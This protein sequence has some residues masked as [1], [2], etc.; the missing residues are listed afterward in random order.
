MKYLLLII[1]CFVSLEIKSQEISQEWVRSFSISSSG[2]QVANDAITDTEG[3][4]YVTGY[5]TSGYSQADMVTVK[6]NSLGEYQWG[7]SYY[8]PNVGYAN[9]IGMCIATYSNAGSDYIYAAGEVNYSGYTYYIAVVKY[10]ENGNQKWVKG[11]ALAPFGFN[12][13]L[14]KIIADEEGN[15][16][17]TGGSD[18]TFLVKLD[19]SGNTKIS[20]TYI[21]PSGYIYGKGND[22]QVSNGGDIYVF[23]QITNS[24]ISVRIPFIMKTDSAGIQQ[25]FNYLPAVTHNL[26]DIEGKI[27]ISAS[28]NLYAGCRGNTDYKII[29]YNSSGDTLWT[30]RYNGVSNGQDYFNALDIDPEENVYATGRVNG[31]YGDIGTVKYDSSGV[32]QWIQTIGGSGGWDDEGK[33]IEIDSD[34][35]AFVTGYIDNSP[36]GRFI[37]LKYNP[38]GTLLWSREYDFAPSDYE[39]AIA[40]TIDNNGNAIS[41]GIAGYTTISDYA[42]LK[43]NSA[44]TLQWAKK[45]NAS[46]ISTDAVNSIAGDKNGN[47]Y[48]VGRVRTTQFGDNIQLVKYNSAGVKKWDFNLGGS[49]T[50]SQ[51]MEDAGNDVTV[52]QSGNVYITGTMHVSVLTNKRDVYTQKL[53]SNGTPLWSYGIF[54]GG[55][56]EEEGKEIKVDNSGNVYVGFN[57]DVNGTNPDCGVI[58][59]NSSG[60]LVWAYGYN[61]TSNDTDKLT[62]MK[63][64]KDGN[65][66]LLGNSKTLSN[67]FD[68]F[69]IKLN[70]STGTVLWNNIFNGSANGN[71]EGRSIDTDNNGNAYITGTAFNLTTGNDLFAIKYSSDG[72]TAWSN[73][74]ISGGNNL[75]ETGAVIKFDSLNLK[76]KISGDLESTLVGKLGHYI[77]FIDS[78][79]NYNPLNGSNAIIPGE[80]FTSGGTL[81]AAGNLITTS[82]Y[83]HTSQSTDMVV[84]R[85]NAYSINF[86]GQYSGNDIPAINE[87]VVSTGNYSYAG[88]SSYDSLKG[89]VM[90]IVKYRTSVYNIHLKFFIQGFYNPNWGNTVT[91]TVKLTLRNSS[92]P[93]NK[94]D[95]AKIISTLEGNAFAYF[96]NISGNNQYYI[97]FNHRNSVE[98]WSSSPVTF[99]P[100]TLVVDF[101]DTANVFGANLIRIDGNYSSFTIYNGDV[102]QDGLV[103]GTDGILIDNDVANFNTGYLPTDLNGDEII[104]GSDAVIAD[105]NASNFVSSITP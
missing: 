19:S 84:W 92:P 14:R 17:V 2:A 15:V 86:N 29:K 61:G 1:L 47:I 66:Y 75:R 39:Y 101:K 73:T 81:D 50:S 77:T 99:S 97:T 40:L 60:N 90:T 102:N 32:F 100:G 44:G 26:G 83:K 22:I 7:K 53:D 80:N 34:G 103:D 20:A 51:D 65:V 57:S 23:G 54:Y 96:Y 45:F 67:G 87:S 38:A 24:S 105:N 76:T 85:Q 30:R 49:Y 78:S 16:Y 42:T 82:A 27:K 95:S 25:Y 31:L 5:N 18:K 33:D 68:V 63:I 69:T 35:N 28:G 93:F 48:A 79:G 13:I 104:D 37:T 91:D 71:D 10:D 6:Y 74:Q 21:N 88:V 41:A 58:K 3:N 52:D 98:T 94:I 56:R 64:D 46:Q 70:S 36:G 62:D 55:T 72:S 43:Y 4:V 12:M 59:Y 11:I 8:N 89:Y 9:E